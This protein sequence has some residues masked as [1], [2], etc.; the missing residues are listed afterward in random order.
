[1]YSNSSHMG[2]DLD[3]LT[4]GCRFRPHRDLFIYLE[5][6]VWACFW[7]CLEKKIMEVLVEA[8][9]VC[10]KSLWSLGFLLK[11]CRF[12]TQKCGSLIIEKKRGVCLRVCLY[13]WVTMK[14]LHV[15]F[16]VCSDTVSPLIAFSSRYAWKA[17]WKAW[18]RFSWS[19][20]CQFK[21]TLM[22]SSF[23]RYENSS[24]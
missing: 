11:G 2:K 13:V 14:H 22:A 24:R 4:K 23:D 15:F 18:A 7:E 16:S 12:E 17:T 21:V 8:N 9:F 20:L 19:S 1:M 5:M 6:F 3:W 10:W